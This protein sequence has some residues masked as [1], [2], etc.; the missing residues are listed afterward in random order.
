MWAIRN[1]FWS[2]LTSQFQYQLNTANILFYDVSLRCVVRALH[3]VHQFQFL[4][5][6]TS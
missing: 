6:V 1:Q 4:S 2:S 5:G 3:Y